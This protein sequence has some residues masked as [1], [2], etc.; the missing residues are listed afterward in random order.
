MSLADHPDV[1][2]FVV[3]S[4]PEDATTDSRGLEQLS[5]V[6]EGTRRR[7]S[8]V[9]LPQLSIDERTRLAEVLGPYAQVTSEHL[10]APV[11]LAERGDALVVPAPEYV[12]LDRLVGEVRPR[13][14]GQVV[15]VVAPVAA[16]LAA[17]AEA[18]LAHGEVGEHTVSIDV[19]GRPRLLGAGTASALHALAPREI[20]EPTQRGDADD[21]R[22]MLR[23]LAD[24]V[25]D[26]AFGTLV[27]SLA[28]DEAPPG[29]VADR[30]LAEVGP[31][32]LGRAE[33]DD[34]PAPATD[35]RTGTAQHRSEPG[36]GR[37][38]LVWAVAAAVALAATGGIVWFTS[39]RGDDATT[40][41]GERTDL[42]APRGPTLSP[43]PEATSSPEASEQPDAPAD[44]AADLS[45][46][47]TELCGAPAP[48][49][50][51]SPPLAENWV[52]VVDELYTRRSAAL[53][54]GQSSLLCEVYDPL[55]PGL[56]SDLELEAAYAEQGVRPDAL[57]FVV[58]EAALVT[59]EGV[60]LTLRITDRLEPYSLLD[61]DGQ[62]VAELP[63]IPGKTWQARLVPDPT[64]TAW[65]FG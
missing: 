65:R 37:R 23:G 13:S 61:A 12:T 18:G 59:Q 44:A 36:A 63:G 6:E 52:D 42:P 29:Q 30:L 7:V 3:T 43:S 51:Q 26:A 1:P 64:G 41:T 4:S 53:V 48:A 9:L 32:P 17:L 46:R 27:A 54:T 50:E 49:P 11:T 24:A 34:Q 19:D 55:S 57:V 45:A 47:G 10:A 20:D 31:A 35:E 38:R 60:L 8:L 56:T 21:L 58:D 16:A 28:A 22:R 39:T 62:V 2:G 33:A 15:T 5:A 25:D 40:A 14:P